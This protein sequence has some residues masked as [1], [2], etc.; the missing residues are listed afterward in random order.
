MA[1]TFNYN[2]NP[3]DYK[4]AQGQVAGQIDPLFNRAIQAV[5]QQKYQSDVQAGQVAANR[6]L[7][8][9][10]LAADQLNKIA[11][12]S[13][14]QVSDLNAQRATQIAQQ[15]NDLVW[16]DKEFALQDRSQKYNEFNSDRGYNYQA[17]RDKIADTRYTNEWNY[18]VGRDKISDQRYTNET[19][20]SH[21]RDKADDA[22]RQKEWS[23]MSPAE[24][25]RMAL[26]N[27]YS[28]KASGG[29][30]GGGGGGRRS[31]GRRSS[32]HKSNS[33]SHSQTNT[34]NHSNDAAY[35]AY[36]RFKAGQEMSRSG[37]TVHSG[38]GY[39]QVAK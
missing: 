30:G 1:S 11:I 31:S 13:Q 28:K 38:S 34:N 22:W 14:G 10:G 35:Q 4:T 3:L 6:G 25:A 29:G 2:Y 36:L 9:S 33:N 19:N 39:T 12:A 16:R 8:H 18:N 5:N 24:K 15:A 37:G 27:S 23:Q 7:G 20:Y 32:G 26:Q 21:A 17:G